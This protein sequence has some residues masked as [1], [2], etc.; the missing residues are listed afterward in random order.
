MLRD[1]SSGMRGQ[2]PTDKTTAKSQPGS[3][4]VCATAHQPPPESHLQGPE[5]QRCSIRKLLREGRRVQLP[6]PGAAMHASQQ[7]GD[8]CQAS[9]AGW[10]HQATDSRA[11]C[12]SSSV[13]SFCPRRAAVSAA[14]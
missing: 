10:A 11:D 14:P 1:S 12:I 4:T 6:P 5:G 13:L 8:G 9:A 3:S 2:R 7:A